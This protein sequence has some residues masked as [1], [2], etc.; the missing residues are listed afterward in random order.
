[1]PDYPRLPDPPEPAPDDTAILYGCRILYFLLATD[2]YCTATGDQLAL[3]EHA[4]YVAITAP[5]ILPAAVDRLSAVRHEI[6]ATLRRRAAEA[7]QPAPQ[8][9]CLAASAPIDGRTDG[10]NGNGGPRIPRRPYPIAP[11]AGDTLR[12]PVRIDF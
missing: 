7:P 4:S 5:G 3:A 12:A 2:V 6:S 8:A 11:A 10:Y 1:M 9:G